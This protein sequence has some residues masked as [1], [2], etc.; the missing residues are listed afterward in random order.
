MSLMEKLIKS[1]VLEEGFI[2][3]KEQLSSS[4]YRIR[5]KSE[6]I[7]SLSFVAGSFLR[8]GVGL[9]Q[10]ELS[11]K[12][13]IRSYSIWHIDQ[14]QGFVDIA[15]AT[16]IN[17][18][19]SDWIKRCGVGDKVYFKTKKGNFLADA[20]ADSY[21]MVGDLSALSHLYMLRR[22]IGDN[23]LIKGLIYNTERKELFADVDGSL[24]FDLSEMQ[25]EN[26]N[27]LLKEVK[28][29]LPELIGS[30]KV[31]IAGDSRIC[32]ALHRYFK[33]EAAWSVKQIKT[34]PF[35]NPLKKGLE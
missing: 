7:K 6:S 9:G 16:H 20:S 18:V 8:M 29:I 15:V 23:K 5:L 2:A 17:G 21:L 30:P 1:V 12:D 32:V 19:G 14:E 34:K 35:W 31:Y 24:P 26:V 28:T 22:N 25:G 33:E 27:V 3:E 11:L 4:A 13:K 10:D